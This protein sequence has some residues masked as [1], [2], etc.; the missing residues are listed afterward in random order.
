VH[1]QAPVQGQPPAGAR[2]GAPQAQTG[3]LYGRLVDPQGKPVSYATV[4]LLRA[5]SSVVNGDLTKD[6]GSFTIEPTGNGKFRLRISAIGF[7]PKSIDNIII[8]GESPEKDLGK[9]SLTASATQLK[10]VQVTGERPLIEMSVDKKT[11]NVEKNITTA[12]GSATDVLQNVPAVSVDVDGNV[13]LRGKGNVTILIDGKPATLLGGDATS[14]LQS[15]PAASIQSVEVITNP[16][17]KY[18]AQGM[19]GI[20]NI[21]TKKDNKFGVNGTLTLGAGTRDKYNGS[22]GFNLRNKK[23]NV[24]LN[25]NFRLN[26]NYNYTTNDLRPRRGDTFSHSFEDNRRRFNGWFNSFGAEYTIDNNNSVTLTE[27]VNVMD[28]S[29]EGPADYR[30]YA[31]PGNMVFERRRYTSG[32]GGPTSL[33]T[34][35]DYKH[36]FH[37]EKQE[38]TANA[39]FSQS[40]MKR[41]QDYVT[42]SL[43]GN[44]V[45][46]SGS[47]VQHAPASGGNTSFNGQ[48]DFTTPFLTPKGKLDA[49]VKA[50]LFWFESGN[51]PLVTYPSGET[52]VDSVLLNGYNYNQKTYAGYINYSDQKG[53]LGYQ[54]GLRIEDAVYEGTIRQLGGKR[55]TNDFLNL[56][57][58][59]FLSYKLPKD[60]SIYLNYSRRT[61]RPDFRQLMPYLDLSNPQDTS[62]GNPDLKPEFINNAELSYNRL[63]KKGHNIIVSVYYQYT[64]NLI[65]RYRRYNADFT[66]FTQPRNLSSGSTYGLELTGRAQLL[67]V[68]DA[69]LNVNFFQN[70]VNG[71]NIDPSLNNS[72]F[73]WLSKINTNLRLPKGFSFQANANYESPKVAG[74]GQLQ[75]VWW[76]DAAIRKNLWNNK[77]TVVF[78]VSDIF[79]TRKYTTIYDLPVYYQTTYRDRE[80]R[81][82]NISFTWRFGKSDLKSQSRRKGNQQQDKT[83][84]N[85]KGDDSGDQGGF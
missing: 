83:R 79:N 15:L 54:A 84:D 28:F 2:P 9:V 45:P 36:K 18:D 82:A 46:L 81:V 60:Q 13:S 49:G 40:W 29:G 30:T 55:Y 12:G 20:I 72:G 17:A 73:S 53:N 64:E 56:F 16:S 11:F 58:S 34:S 38:L 26:S 71:A 32:S 25:S 21:V 61:N 66:T 50:Q 1:A 76:I 67:P 51:A 14:A 68:W 43:D 42:D 39:T 78:N 44:E 33:S 27:N 52:K 63:F 8:T 23:W 7:Q 4:T 5:D 10:E 22:L 41:Q 75:D 74:Q 80:T 24:F 31:S 65:E 3:K 59:V 85:L 77:A 37:K 57:P 69:T 47:T 6:N 48:A 62:M 35:L 70:E 19:T